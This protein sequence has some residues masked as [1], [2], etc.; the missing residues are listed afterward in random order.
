MQIH[1]KPHSSNTFLDSFLLQSH[2]GDPCAMV[3]KKSDFPFA[4][5]IKKQA[6]KALTLVVFANIS[7]LIGW[8]WKPASHKYLWM[9]GCCY[10]REQAKNLTKWIQGIIYLSMLLW[11]V[12]GVTLQCCW[13]HL[14]NMNLCWPACPSKLS[15]SHPC[16]GWCTSRSKGLQPFPPTLPN[17]YLHHCSHL[18]DHEQPRSMA[19]TKTMIKIQ[20]TMTLYSISIYVG[21]PGVTIGWKLLCS[22]T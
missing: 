13:L 20:L 17:T 8:L 22:W 16:F 4:K 10:R 5:P 2:F 19:R 3:Q 12:H 1:H 6:A 14:Q 18:S 9:L 7:I 15:Q 11:C 21:R